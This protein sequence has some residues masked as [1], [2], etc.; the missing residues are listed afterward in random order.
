M[1]KVLMLSILGVVGLSQ[2]AQAET[3]FSCK[4]ENN[5]YIEVQKINGNLYEYNFGRASKNELSI[6]NKKS[7]LLGRSEKWDGFGRS[8][9]ANMNFQNGEYM[10]SVWV[11]FD[12]IEH[13]T[14][15]GVTVAR[16]GKTIANVQCTPETAQ[17]NFDDS[18]FAW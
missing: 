11:D 17:A 12:S 10:Y 13:T 18:E 4:T 15:S 9:W 7:E 6:R 2:S 14:N 16:R 8:R 3:I 5:K 1:K